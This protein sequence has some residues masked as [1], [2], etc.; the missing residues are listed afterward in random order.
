MSGE[1]RDE[2][3]DEKTAEATAAPETVYTEAELK[4]RLDAAAEEAKDRHLRLAAEYDN[5][6][7][8][9]A[10]EK[11]QWTN[12]AIERFVMDLLPVLDDFDRAL[13]VKTGEGDALASGIRLTEKSMR[14]ALAKHGVEPIDPLGAKFDPN[15]HEAIQRAPKGDAAAGTVLAVFGKGYTLKGRLLRPARVL[16]AGDS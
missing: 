10:R 7:R 13:A 6:R 3:T 5:Y 12:E 16:V 9:V 4:V 15:L 1:E 8:R 11:E 14:A 2:T